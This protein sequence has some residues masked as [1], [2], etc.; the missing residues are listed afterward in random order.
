MEGAAPA[1]AKRAATSVGREAKPKVAKKVLS[2][3]E[4]V[5]EAAKRRCRRK[6]QKN[7]T[8]AV[9]NQQAGRCRSAGRASSPPSDLSGGLHA[10]QERGIAGVAPPASVSSVS[11]QLRPGT[12]APLQ[13]HPALRFVSGL[14]P[15]QLTGAP[16]QFNGVAVP[17][18]NRT[19][20]SGDSCP[21][22]THKTRQVPEESMPQPHILFDEMAPPAPKMDDPDYWKDRHDTDIQAIIFG[23]GFVRDDR[24]G[25]GPHDDWAPTQHAEDIETAQLF[26]T[27]QTQPTPV[28]VD[29]F[30]DAP[31][32]SVPMNISTKKKGESR[33]IQGFID[34]GD[35]CLCEAWLVTSHD[36]ING[37]QQ[38]GKVYWAKVLQQ[39]N[40]TKMHPPYHIPSPRTEESLRKRWNYLKQETSKFCSAVE[41]A[42]NHPVSGTGVVLVVPRV[43]EKFRVTH[44]KGF[45]MVHCW[46][47]LKDAEKWKT[48]FASNNEAVRNG[49]AVNLDGEDDDQ[50]CPAL[51]PRP[52]GHK[53]TK[54]DLARKAQAIAFTQ[55][56]E[57]IMAG[58]LAAL[59]ARDEKRR[60]EKEAV[61]AIYHNLAKEVIEVQRMDVE[62]KKADAEAKL[63]D[64]FARR[65]DTEAKTR[66]E[67]TRIMLVDL[68]GVD[69][70]TRAWFMTRHAE[71]RA[72]DA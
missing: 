57:K 70:D 32:Q 23:G 24:A 33:R 67:D 40:E 28:S 31:T 68:S 11:S 60:L 37:A 61:V 69:D 55:S 54:A 64:A 16:E 1:E 29:D 72:R 41:H 22:A 17:D 45:H 52:R 36:C 20:R 14:P 3:E 66:A 15:V 34:D 19:P 42:V 44:K 35:K 65:M 43:L 47:V 13:V 62:A 59:A 56:M 63:R 71:I 39:Y 50:G 46:D 18:L 4:K 9:A 49:T 48:S 25:T 38:K 5:I 8:A 12:P 2:K 30:D 6:N 26:A 21:G 27:Q 53:A 10:R 7:K 58:N 51:P